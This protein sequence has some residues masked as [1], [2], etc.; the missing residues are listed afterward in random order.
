MAPD[1]TDKTDKTT[2]LAQSEWGIPDWRDTA[3]YGA[4]TKWN[5]GRWRWEFYRRRNDVREY[6]DNNVAERFNRPNP[7]QQPLPKPDKPG[8]TVPV[9]ARLRN[10]IGY[11]NLP[12]PRISEQPEHI[13]FPIEYDETI[14]NIF[15]DRIGAHGFRGTVGDLL[16]IAGI[17]LTDEH[18]NI[19]GDVGDHFPIPIERDQVAMVFDMNKPLEP[20]MKR[21]KEI[22][23]FGYKRRRKP[24]Q[25]KR[26]PKKWLMYVR[27]LDARESG[28]SWREISILH[29]N[30]AQTE[31]TSRDIFKA[32]DALRNNF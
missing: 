23:R 28:A 22:L 19:I 25:R 3:A 10:V 29:G 18:A 4:S 32:A 13:L 31:Q 6:F 21:A 11:A 24:L 7:F 26:H 30:T 5:F 27:T 12:N 16:D 2:S 1:K 9:E 15:G 8:F 17:Q 20:Q 14:E